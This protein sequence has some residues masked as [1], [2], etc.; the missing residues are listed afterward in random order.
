MKIS[1][2]IENSGKVQQLVKTAHD[3]FWK[4]GIRRVTI[5]EIC[6]K[7]KVSKMTFYKHFK[8]KIDLVI[9]IYDQLVAESMKRYHE[10]MEADIKY[11]EK[12]RRI[13]DL[14]MDQTEDLSKEFFSDI[15]GDDFPEIRAYIDEKSQESMQIVVNDFLRAQK[16]G[17][18][19]KNLK[20]EFIHYFLNQVM[21]MARDKELIALYD[22]PQDL[23]MEL[24]NLFFY[25]IIH[26]D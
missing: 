11:E 2:P 9:Y 15:Y 24:T 8:N 14:K 23:I 25:G 20:P 16:K 4:H 10:I 1:S 26:R 13:I 3:L 18:L 22:N 19:R 17:E 7:A 6:G 21:L 12:V 5:E